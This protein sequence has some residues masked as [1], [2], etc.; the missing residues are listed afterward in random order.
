MWCASARM[1]SARIA[2]ADPLPPPLL[3][4]PRA[5]YLSPVTPPPPPNKL[6]A[7]MRGR[8]AALSGGDD[9]GRGGVDVGM[10][11]VGGRET[12]RAFAGG[13]APAE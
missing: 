5:I 2:T 11:E 1:M 8:R 4:I 3:P 9:N 7:A 13:T 12:E 6:A 10:K